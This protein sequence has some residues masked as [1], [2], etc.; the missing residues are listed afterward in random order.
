MKTAIEAEAFRLCAAHLEDVHRIMAFKQDRGDKDLCVLG[1]I[2][3][4]SLA[5]LQ[6]DTDGTREDEVPRL[7]AATKRAG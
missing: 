3:Q 5:C 6:P 7:V 2:R 4:G 1:E